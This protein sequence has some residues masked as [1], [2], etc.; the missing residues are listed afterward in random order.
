[1]TNTQ[2]PD[3]VT[4]T[5]S[6]GV[7]LPAG[8]DG[9]GARRDVAASRGHDV[10]ERDHVVVR[11]STSVLPADGAAQLRGPLLHTQIT[12]IRHQAS[13]VYSL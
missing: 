5:L 3:S 2:F 7:L 12:Q 13:F 8:V 10:G 4:E 9:D 11:V 6:H 1:M